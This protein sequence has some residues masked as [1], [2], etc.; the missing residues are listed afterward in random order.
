MENSILQM[1]PSAYRE[2]W[3]RTAKEQEHLQEIRL[4]AG[5]PIVLQMDG[6]EVFLTA[7]GDFTHGPAL[8][9]RGRFRIC[10]SIYVTI[11]RMPLRRSCVKALSP[12]REDIGWEWRDKQC[13]GLTAASGLPQAR[14]APVQRLISLRNPFQ[15]LC[16]ICKSAMRQNGRQPCWPPGLVKGQKNRLLPA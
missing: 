7:Q 2:F 16:G 3:L 5:R 1:F 4:R 14:E 10:W 13:W 9:G 8:Q 6:R 15:R 12:W 11:R